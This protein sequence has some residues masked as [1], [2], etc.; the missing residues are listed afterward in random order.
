MA[1]TMAMRLVR[2]A[3]LDVGMQQAEV[4]SLTFN[5]CRRF[6]PTLANVLQY[7]RHESQAVGNWVEDPS[8]EQG[9]RPGSSSSA[10]MPM[11]VHY[12]GQQALASG[13]VKQR[14]LED[15]LAIIA[16]VPAAQAIVLGQPGRIG[17]DVLSWEIVAGKHQVLKR[18]HESCKLLLADSQVGKVKKERK[19]NKEH[20]AKRSAR[21]KRSAS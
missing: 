10:S 16:E 2:Q 8:N 15:F 1:H 21:P 5:T 13:M 3:F 20:K 7:S 6:L 18:E 4:N 9:R 14:L 19:A 12:S 11:S 17:E